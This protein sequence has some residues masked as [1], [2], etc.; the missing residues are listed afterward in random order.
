MFPKLLL[1]VAHGG[2]ENYISAFKS[3]DF[4]VTAEYSSE[5]FS[6]DALVLCGGGDISPEF[7]GEKNNGSNPPDIMRD[8]SELIL[9]EKYFSAKKPIIGICRGCQLINVALGGKLI[10]H[11]DTFQ[12]HV[13][14]FGTD[15]VHEVSNVGR[16]SFIEFFGHSMVVNSAHHQACSVL[17]EGLSISQMHG[18]GT[19]EAIEG[20]RILGM[21]W[22]P[23]RMIGKFFRPEFSGGNKIF[24]LIKKIVYQI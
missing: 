15:L 13:S 18:D 10:Q 3:F 6:C 1:S 17:G 4:E 2:A 7:F 16:S 5:R 14:K 23:E 22:H 21:Q 9:F 20:E 8:K 11:L 12:N 19:V 24:E